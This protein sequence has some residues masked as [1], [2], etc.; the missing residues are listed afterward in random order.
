M[1]RLLL[2]FVALYPP[3]VS[4]AAYLGRLTKQIQELSKISVVKIRNSFQL[5]GSRNRE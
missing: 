5:I 3:H 4:K 2:G 1:I